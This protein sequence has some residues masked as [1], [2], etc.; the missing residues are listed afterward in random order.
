MAVRVS[1]QHCQELGTE[2][3]LGRSVGRNQ[4]SINYRAGWGDLRI[5]VKFS[6]TTDPKHLPYL[7]VLLGIPTLFTDILIMH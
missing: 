4:F 6:G 3:Q 7:P 2:V 5:E 1:S